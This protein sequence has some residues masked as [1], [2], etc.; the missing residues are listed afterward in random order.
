MAVRI[1][2]L[3]LVFLLVAA[4]VAAAPALAQVKAE[5]QRFADG[6]LVRK[7]FESTQNRGRTIEIWDLVVAPG[8]TTEEFRLPRSGV[9]EVRSGQGAMAV[10]GVEKDRLLK[11]GDTFAVDDGAA[12]KLTNFDKEFAMAL[13]AVLVSRHKREADSDG[14]DKNKNTLIGNIIKDEGGRKEDPG[15]I[16]PPTLRQPIYACASTVVLSNFLPGA[17]LEVMADGVS[18]GSM[19]SFVTQGQ[20]VEVSIKFTAGQSIT[21][22][23]HF[24]GATSG[25][26]NE[27]PVTSH[28][29]D[30][31][32][33]LPK[34]RL[35][36]VALL[37]CGRAVGLDDVI[38]GALTEV[39]SENPDPVGGF[40]A[41]VK[42]GQVAD[43]PYTF[44]SPAFEKDARVHAVSRLCTD[45][46]PDSNIEI[47]QPEPGTINSPVVAPVN[48]SAPIV[49]VFG[50]GGQPNASFNGATLDVFTNSQPPGS[51]R[52]GGQP[53]PGGGGQHVLINPIAAGGAS[54]WATQALCSKSKS[55]DPTPVTPC[56][57]MPPATIRPPLPGD[58][59]V[60]LIDFIPGAE[61]L[62]FADGV[63]IG[64]SGPSVINLS[65][66]VA[67][68]ETITVVQRLAKCDSS[69]V[70]VIDVDC[71]QLGGND[72][73]C[74]GEWPA[75][76]HN[77][78]R[79]ANQTVMSALANPYKVK[80]LDKVWSFTPPS[81]KAFRASPIV[82]GGR[83]FIGNG[84]GR[85]FALDAAS[86]AILWQYPP[87]GEPPLESQF[88]S[89]PSSCGIAASASMG[90]FK[91]EIDVVVFGAPDQSIG[92]KLGSGRLFALNAASG[93]EVWK[94]PE[95]ARLT[96]LNKPSTS[97]LHE[98]F[99]YSS[100]LVFEDKVYIGI[101]N[102]GDNPVQ[103]GRVV[104]VDMNNGNIIGG[105]SFNA[106]ST[107][108]GGV[109]SSPAGGFEGGG[110]YVTTGNAKC[111]AGGCQ[112]EPKVN[113]SLSML[114]LDQSGGIVWKHQPVPFELDG[115]PDWASGV[116]LMSTSCG[117]LAA[118][119]MKDGWAYAA[120][121]GPLAGNQADVAWQFPA[122]GFPFTAGDGTAHGDTRYLVPGAAWQ[123]TFFTMSGGEGLTT[124]TGSGL[125]RLHALNACSGR[126]NRVRWLADVPSASPESI[127]QLGPPTV[128]HGIVYIGTGSG[129]LVALADPSVWPKAGSRCSHPDVPLADCA[130]SGLPI[131]PQP[132]VLRDIDLG[133]GAILSEP[134]LAD[135]RVFVST[136]SSC[137]DT[138]TLHM[139]APK[140]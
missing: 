138:G 22:R 89:N 115:D 80:T 131:V 54:F 57:D 92:A 26:S 25:L 109:W 31:P 72:Q 128:T 69:L 98:Q 137:G 86:G 106:T 28:L 136:G 3:I 23:Q 50:P 49:T 24:S 1:R 82:H 66:P 101:A 79:T 52:V 77:G 65:R 130:A 116:A 37:Q 135:G 5:F 100:P 84:N 119:T 63:E 64:H 126:G 19:E 56:S 81:A 40:M 104:S 38:P 53:T 48:E 88:S 12:L 41:P 43:F 21:A 13:R 35:T 18:V 139:L 94:S 71:K 17:K 134:V 120:R 91:N 87:A 83:V 95:I 111:W 8:K 108:G 97:E 70:H 14:G 42:V 96:G 9:F 7:T 16:S 34:P 117:E 102:H 68:G 107:R 93:A 60:T 118:S 133:S 27:V 103:N 121:P 67:N 11:T 73:A 122:T 90:R 124:T 10:A 30:F 58:T 129:H 62:I 29:E 114:R 127:Y 55:S 76:R 132:S 32:N 4:W 44:I 51:E 47:V 125:G 112:N 20:N 2:A 85:F 110:V 140:K 6:L 45:V 75:F 123:D 61:I 99:G 33:G 39:L 15:F 74:L 113:H 59:S 36:P 105:Y 46:S 78:L